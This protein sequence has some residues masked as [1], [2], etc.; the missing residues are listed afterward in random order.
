MTFKEHLIVNDVL[1]ER[2]DS[3]KAVTVKAHKRF[4]YTLEKSI[5]LLFSE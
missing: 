2:G 5:D 4:L 3:N 1:S